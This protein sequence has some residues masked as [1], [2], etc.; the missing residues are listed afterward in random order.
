MARHIGVV[1]PP[2]P[3]HFRA[4]Q[5]LAE[6]LVARGHRV[7]FLQQQEA[8]R[9][10]D[11]GQ[12]SF[13]PVGHTS[14][15]PG[16]LARTLR[17]AAQPG[18]PLGLRRLI[19]DMS[20][21]TDMLCRELP[22]A[23]DELGIDALICDQME[24]A[25]GLVAEASGRA[26]VSVACAL[27]VNREPGLP[28][29]VMPFA[30]GE[31][32]RRGRVYAGSERTY[33]MLMGEHRRTVA[34][35]AAA[36]GLSRREGLHECLSPRAQISQTVAGLEL[37][38]RH[39]PPHFHHVGPLRPAAPAAWTSEPKLAP[40]KPVVF[41]SLGT[42]Q[43]HRLT[44]F[45]RI[46]RACRPFGAQLLVAHCGGLDQRQEEALWREGATRVT[47]FFPQRAVLSRADAVITHGGLNTVMDALVARTPMLVLPLAFDQPGVA[48]RVQ[49]AGVGLR[50]SPRFEGHRALSVKLEKLLAGTGFAAALARLG[51]E[52]EAAGGT[53]R[54][55]AIVEEAFL[56]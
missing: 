23:L 2:F 15:P 19:A 36:F 55:T 44:L 7:T 9:W 26:F 3:S 4:L 22:R 27:P 45:R 17:L 11:S 53:P 10:L 21:T 13:H 43:G 34:Y 48:T 20:R 6:A 35:H 24:A 31:S 18:G 1:A 33:D 41:A 5:A 30:Y 51:E 25:G 16:S 29:P 38:R 56:T 14:H 28:L 52:V 8:A 49:H 54:A 40:D 39:L 46:A 42:L 12:V 50:A 47:S 37:P 32:E